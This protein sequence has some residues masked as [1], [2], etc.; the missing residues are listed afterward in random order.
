MCVACCATCHTMLLKHTDCQQ[1]TQAQ[2]SLPSPATALQIRHLTCIINGTQ[3]KDGTTTCLCAHCG[4]TG[5]HSWDC[6][7][8]SPRT[9]SQR[10]RQLLKGSLAT[11]AKQRMCAHA[12]VFCLA[13][14]RDE[15]EEDKPYQALPVLGDVHGHAGSRTWSSAQLI[16]FSA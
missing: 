16:P 1:H 2:S 14:C 4:T 11:R 3:S 12:T 9:S 10:R 8:S 7:S 13:Q 6:K 15:Q 5:S